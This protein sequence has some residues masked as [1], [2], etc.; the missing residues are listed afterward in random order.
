MALEGFVIIFSNSQNTSNFVSIFEIMDFSFSFHGLS[1]LGFLHK[2][3]C[4]PWWPLF[5][6]F[7]LKA[8]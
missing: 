4:I 3:I 2:F 1:C 5:F 8:K 7:F 6:D